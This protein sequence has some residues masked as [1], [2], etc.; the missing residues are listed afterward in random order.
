MLTLFKRKESRSPSIYDIPGP[1]GKWLIGDAME[2]D[3]DPV[4]WMLRTKPIYGDVVR[5]DNETIVVHDPGLINQVFAETNNDFLLDNAT[6]SGSKGREILLEGLKQWMQSRKYLG[7]A[8]NRNILTRHISRAGASLE[9]EVRRLANKEVDLF[10]ASQ[11]VLGHAIADFCIGA[12]EEFDQLFDAVEAVFWAS[13]DVTDSEETR[14]PWASRPIAKRAERLNNE[15]VDLLGQAVKRRRAKPQE[16]APHRDALDQLIEGLQDAPEAQIVAAT[17]LMMVTAHGPSG[18]I[19]S[20][21]LL[22]LAE[23][24]SLIDKLREELGQAESDFLLPNKYPL[25][26]AVLRETMRMHPANWLMGRTAQRDT[27]LGRYRIPEDC[28]VLFSPYVVHRDERFWHEPEAFKPERWLAKEKPHVENAYFPFG[29][30]PRICPG[31]LLGPIQLMLGLK[32]IL[33]NFDLD[34]PPLASAKPMHSTLLR[35]E[36]LRGRWVDRAS[37]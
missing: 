4:G 34:L 20:W 17:R 13:L 25:T 23:N 18:S 10:D 2:F 35:P 36:G 27:Q 8:L 21:C 12:D 24:P 31:A 22:R 29:A 14:L 9:R 30:G 11:Y 3:K 37:R 26:H 5:L 7:K 32:A 33:L 16:G 28:R 15:L 6:V 1:K 19:F